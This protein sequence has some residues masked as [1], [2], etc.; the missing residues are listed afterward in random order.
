MEEPATQQPL[1]SVDYSLGSWY[2]LG[3]AVVI[4][5]CNQMQRFSE[6]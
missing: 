1:I 4:S 3:L 5:A 2:F 6:H